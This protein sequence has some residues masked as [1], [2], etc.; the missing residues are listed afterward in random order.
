MAAVRDGI[1]NELDIRGFEGY[2]AQ[3]T[4]AATPLQF[5][6]VK[7]FATSGH[8][9]SAH[10]L[11]RISRQAQVFRCPRRQLVQVIGRQKGL[12]SAKG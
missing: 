11:N 10:L 3:R 4:L 5:D 7:L 8:V 1:V 2:P 6:L 12:V 9:L